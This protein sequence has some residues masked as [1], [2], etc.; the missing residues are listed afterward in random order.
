MYDIM[1]QFR[2]KYCPAKLTRFH[3]FGCNLK[4]CKQNI[5]VVWLRWK[6]SI[7]LIIPNNDINKKN[8]KKL[9][10]MGK[11]SLFLA[12]LQ[13]KQTSNSK[14]TL[15]I[16]RQSK[17]FEKTK[18]FGKMSMIIN[19]YIM[20]IHCPFLGEKEVLDLLFGIFLWCIR[21]SLR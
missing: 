5:F 17:C 12:H 18:L 3:V 20:T 7:I 2:G 4:I 6:L 13:G 19:N 10:K 11:Y 21:L 8:H 14:V 9:P 1:P 16:K 15:K